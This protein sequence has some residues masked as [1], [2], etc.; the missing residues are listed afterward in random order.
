[1]FKKLNFIMVLILSTIFSGNVQAVSPEYRDEWY[2]YITNPTYTTVFQ[3][4]I[5]PFVEPSMPQIPTCKDGYRCLYDNNGRLSRQFPEESVQGVSND[6]LWSVYDEYPYYS[7]V[8]DTQGRLKS[9][10][11]MEADYNYITENYSYN[12]AGYMASYVYNSGNGDISYSYGDNGRLLEINNDDAGTAYKFDPTTGNLTEY[13]DGYGG[14][15]KFDPTTGNVIEY[16]DDINENKYKFDPI[17][18]KIVEYIPRWEFPAY[19]S[20]D[21]AGNL[22]KI[23]SEGSEATATYEYDENGRRLSETLVISPLLHD[24]GQPFMFYT[25]YDENGTETTTYLQNYDCRL[26]DGS[27]EYCSVFE[28]KAL[29]WSE[30][31]QAYLAYEYDG[32]GY[33]REYDGNVYTYDVYLNKPLESYRSLENILKHKTIADE[34]S[35]AE[36]SKPKYRIYTIDEATKASKPTGNTF[37]LRYR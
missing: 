1:M 31:E 4:N 21:D 8:Y 3:P 7:Y 20:Y 28:D 30:D 14:A 23:E 27:F 9:T 11:E 15:Y 17:T 33:E 19:Y 16:V 5:P 13:D 10:F 34:E 29:I 24:G 35:E 25:T 22:I 12:D 37:K 26:S 18:G 36:N 6:D 2:A 32:N